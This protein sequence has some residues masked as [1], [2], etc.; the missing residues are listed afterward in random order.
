MAIL[1]F[2]QIVLRIPHLGIFFHV[3]PELFYSFSLS[4]LYRSL[5]EIKSC[6][7]M[8]FF[9]HTYTQLCANLGHQKKYNMF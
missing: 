1:Q 9:I 8:Y 5:K 6:I 4:D 3:V 7:C 2:L